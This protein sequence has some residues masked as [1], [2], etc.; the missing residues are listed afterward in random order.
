MPFHDPVILDGDKGDFIAV[1]VQDDSL[2]IDYLKTSA[3]LKV[4]Q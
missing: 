3:H 1:K 4:I 2:G